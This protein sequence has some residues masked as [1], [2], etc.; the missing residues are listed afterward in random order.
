M[1][2]V[3]ESRPWLTDRFVVFRP[4]CP[5]RCVRTALPPAACPPAS[6]DTG[7]AAAGRAGDHLHDSGRT[8]VLSVQNGPARPSA[9]GRTWHRAGWAGIQRPS[10][11]FA[12]P[13]CRSLIPVDISTAA[14]A[15][16]ALSADS[17]LTAYFDLCH[18]PSCSLQRFVVLSHVIAWPAGTR[19]AHPPG[20][21]WASAAGRRRPFRFRKAEGILR[22]CAA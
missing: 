9:A 21:G 17:A 7:R 2:V 13:V 6:C 19:R 15:S 22:A 3:K 16:T 5:R 10:A 8:L 14:T 18:N 1:Q 4:S 12:E 20:T 11:C